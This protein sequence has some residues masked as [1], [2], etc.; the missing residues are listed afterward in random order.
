MGF[1]FRSLR[2]Y[3]LRFVVNQDAG[4]PP[5]YRMLARLRA[6]GRQLRS[7]MLSRRAGLRRYRVYLKLYVPHIQE[8]MEWFAD[9]VAELQD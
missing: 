4:P 7:E 8:W 9:L 3:C 6:N 2:L 5:D 1:M